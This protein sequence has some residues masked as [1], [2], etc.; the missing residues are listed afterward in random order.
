MVH[1]RVYIQELSLPVSIAAM[2]TKVFDD[3]Q[4]EYYTISINDKFSKEKQ[5]SVLCHEL[6]HIYYGDYESL[7]TAD[8]LEFIS[9]LREDV[10]ENYE[11]YVEIINDPFRGDI[12]EHKETKIG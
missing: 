9:L 2:I 12:F 3:S 5:Q 6:E 1:D 8:Q 10:Q 11:A 7:L 4:G